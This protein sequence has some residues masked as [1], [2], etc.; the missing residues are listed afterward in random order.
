MQVNAIIDG[1]N[2]LNPGFEG[3]FRFTADGSLAYYLASPTS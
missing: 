1:S 2:E 3:R